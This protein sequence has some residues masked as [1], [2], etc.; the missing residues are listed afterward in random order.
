LDNNT[1]ENALRPIAVGRKNWLF[2]GND[3]GGRRAAILYSLIETCKRHG[4]DPW[5]YLKD[6]LVRIETQPPESLRQLLPD[7]WKPGRVEPS[8]AGP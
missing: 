8:A 1:A 2:L 6:V 3:E 7:Q 4:H 5:A